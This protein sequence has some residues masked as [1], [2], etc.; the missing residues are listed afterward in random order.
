MSGSTNYG[1][2][3][4]QNNTGE[5]NS[6]FGN[7]AASSNQ[8]GICI[9]A[10]GSN[11]L[12]NN[13]TGPHNTSIG[14]GS[15]FYNKTGDRNTAVGSS[16]LEGPLAPSTT[17]GSQ[18]V[19]IG[20]Q[21]LYSN[22]GDYNVAVGCY[23][24]IDNTTGSNNTAVG[25]SALYSN[26]NG[27]QNTALGRASL[28]FNTTGS[29]NTAIGLG[30]LANNITGSNNTASGFYSLY[31]NIDG[32]NNTAI[33]HGSLYNNIGSSNTAIGLSAGHD[34]SGNSNFNTFLGYNSN[35]ASSSN[36]YNNSTALGYKATIDAS[37]QIVLGG[38]PAGGSYPSVKI[39][40]TYVGIGGVYNPGNGFTLDVLGNLNT[41]MD[42]SINSITVGR[43]GGNNQLNTAVG[44][45]ALQSNTGGNYNTAVGF[46]A[47]TH[48]IGYDENTAVGYQALYSKASGATNTAI[49]LSAGYFDI[50]GNS[51]TFLGGFTDVSNNGFTPNGII[52]NHSTALGYKA[53]IDASNQIVLGGY[54]PVLSVPYPGVKIPGSYVGIGGVYNPSSGYALDVD[55]SANIIG[56]ANFT[57]LGLNAINAIYPVN[58]IY[59]SSAAANMG[60]LFPGTSWSTTS[61]SA[62]FYYTRT[63]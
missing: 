60:T 35:V 46:Q 6:A 9:T 41:T 3:S 47:L 61:V 2:G 1:T 45:E 53:T 18:N 16:A 23:A 42:A 30:S 49:G 26:T 51:N 15:M 17:V 14:A 40:G 36:I 31:K 7:Y 22:Y 11:A 13:T 54:N 24:L 52:Y 21:A 56:N 44:F 39:P 57:G 38:L 59:T 50:S 19:A 28:Y 37:N 48:N 29:V 10:V 63:T 27:T 33:G 20:A 8:S 32:S 25:Y 12:F 43:G 62:P 58:T 55:G 5:N 34:L 4:L